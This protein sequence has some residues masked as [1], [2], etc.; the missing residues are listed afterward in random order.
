MR[1]VVKIIAGLLIAAILVVVG[2]FGYKLYQNG[3]D[4]KKTFGIGISERLIDE[5]EITIA[6]DIYIRFNT[7]NVEIK[8]SEDNKVKVLIYSDREGEHSIREEDGIVNISINEKKLKFWKRLFNHRISRILVYLPKDFEGK[9][10]INGDVGD[11]TLNDYKYAILDTKLNVGDIY[12]DG[13]KDAT[14]DLDVGSVKLKNAYSN[15]NIKVNTGDVRMK[16]A[17][18]LKDSSIDVD[19]GDV[20]IEQTND[21]KIDTKVDVGKADIAKNNEES[22]VTLKITCNVGNI[23]VLAPEEEEE[24]TRND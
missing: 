13:I 23:T 1:V 15:F 16:E 7:S 2:F 3:F 9:I 17:I 21:I 24:K 20:K 5:K 4:F 11:I 8:N 6:K 10:S 18:I 14:I 12:V 22:Q 19:I